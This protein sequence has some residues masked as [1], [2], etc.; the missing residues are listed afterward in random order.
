MMDTASTAER[1]ALK[2][3]GIATS[4]EVTAAI[5]EGVAAK[6]A[7]AVMASGSTQNKIWKIEYSESYTLI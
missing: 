4:N 3:A 2:G 5:R 6:F 7:D 1:L